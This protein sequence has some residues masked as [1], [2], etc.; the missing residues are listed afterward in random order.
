MDKKF[1]IWIAALSMT[2]VSPVLSFA[3]ITVKLPF[4][5][6]LK[7]LEVIHFPLSNLA[8]AQSYPELGVIEEKIPVSDNIAKISTDSQENYLYNLIIGDNE[9]NFIYVAPGDE[10]LVEIASLSPFYSVVSGSEVMDGITAINQELEGLKKEVKEL[11]ASGAQP[12]KEKLD[13]IEKEVRD[14][15]VGFIEE[16]PT[17]PVVAYA[18][19]NLADEDFDKYYSRMSEGA[20]MSIVYPLVEKRVQ[21]MVA[22]KEEEQKKDK[23]HSGNMIAPDFSLENTYGKKISLADFRGKWV[24][25]DFWGSWCIWC[26]KGFPELKDAYSKYNGILEVIG[27]DCNESREAWLDGIRK[28][29]LPWVNLYCPDGNPILREYAVNGFPTKVIIDPEGKIRNFTIGHD[30]EFY[31]KLDLLLSR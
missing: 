26:I 12:S 18:L 30:P 21:Q 23:L 3:E 16:N 1:K 10:I 2:L 15:F 7:E 31:T 20:K 24:I 4:G 28:Y 11:S 5:S 8:K 6:N 19:L 17:S 27:I 13:S 9:Y 14:T 22:K 25:L 29:E